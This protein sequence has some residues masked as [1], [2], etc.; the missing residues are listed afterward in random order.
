MEKINFI[1]TRELKNKTNE[2]LHAAEKGGTIVV[3]RYGKPVA[4]IKSFRENDL[5][6]EKYSLLYEKIR[7]HI[8]EKHPQL[9]AMTKEELQNLNNEISGKVGNFSTWQEM[10]RAAKGDHYGLS[11]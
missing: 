4:T 11:R 8:G 2:I 3:T 10:D 9:L 1:S 7:Q 5:K 6:E